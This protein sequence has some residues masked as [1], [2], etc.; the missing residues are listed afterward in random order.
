[1]S[2]KKIL[3]GILFWIILNLKVSLERLDNSL[4]IHKTV[5]FIYVRRM[6]RGRKKWLLAFRL[7]TFALFELLKGLWITFSVL[8]KMIHTLW[9][10]KFMELFERIL[11]TIFQIEII[12]PN[13]WKHINLKQV[14]QVLCFLSVR[15]LPSLRKF[16]SPCRI[17]CLFLNISG[18]TSSTNL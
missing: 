9:K 14:P 8:L 11:L 16:L 10:L 17:T 7:Y 18:H 15:K 4:K 2:T 13:K 3:A 6:V 12:I 1:M 5:T